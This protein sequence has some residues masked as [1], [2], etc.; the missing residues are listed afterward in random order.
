MSSNYI[1]ANYFAK[2]YS[3]QYFCGLHKL[4]EEQKYSPNQ[5]RKKLQFSIF[6]RSKHQIS[7]EQTIRQINS[8][9]LQFSIF[10]STK[11][12]RKKI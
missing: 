5:L 4:S 9:K 3:S 11:Q 1:V 8:K 7:E 2:K 10:H 6:L 12:F